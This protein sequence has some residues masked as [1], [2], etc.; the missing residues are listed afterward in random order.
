LEKDKEPLSRVMTR[1][2][3]A[4][5]AQDIA[6][7]AVAIQ[8]GA[9]VVFPTDTVYGVGVNAFDEE[10][11]QRLYA[12]KG[13][14][15][16]KGIPILLADRADLAKVTAHVPPLAQT[17]I[18]RFWPGPLTLILPKHPGLPA[19]IS[20]NEGVA[21]RIPDHIAARALI[22]QAGGAVAASSANRSGQSPAQTAEQ[23]LT[24]LDGLVEIILD[25]G[26]TEMSM[27]STIIDCTQTTPQILRLGP[28][29]AADINLVQPENA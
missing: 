16:D 23:A 19:T 29:T 4:A 28:I 8:Q 9:L 5:T 13:R 22:R 12:V 15:S 7:T 26:P 14:P 25:G 24:E 11:V 10:A 1:R 6:A 27:A 20:D 17:L 21:V 3:S 18:D 2:L